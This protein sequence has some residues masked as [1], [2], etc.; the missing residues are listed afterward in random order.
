IGPFIA[1]TVITASGGKFNAFGG[2]A[3]SQG[4]PMWESMDVSIG[5]VMG[6][7]FAIADLVVRSGTLRLEAGRNEY[8]DW[9]LDYQVNRIGTDER[10]EIPLRGQ[11]GVSRLH[12]QVVRQGSSF[13]LD[14]FGGGATLLNGVP[15][16]GHA[17]LNSGDRV[18]IGSANLVFF[19]GAG[20]GPMRQTRGLDAPRGWIS[21]EIHPAFFQAAPQLSLS[22]SFGKCIPLISGRMTVGRD[23]TNAICLGTESSVSRAHAEI[24]VEP[25]GVSVQDLGSTNGTFV[26][27]AR[28]QRSPLK[29]GDTISFGSVVFKVQY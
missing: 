15:L 7:V 26:N 17:F 24:L 18:S 14:D 22:D 29:P 1:V 5:I 21:P 19:T 11:V 16:A 10:S 2:G 9:A 4:V 25:H 27:G 3:L 8:R 6:L 28:I 20:G 13:V 12:A 23:S